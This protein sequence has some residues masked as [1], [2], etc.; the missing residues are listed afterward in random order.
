[1]R[2]RPA[3]Q[4]P[5]SSRA[6]TD[7]A[8]GRLR[9]RGFGPAAWAGFL[10]ECSW[11]SLDQVLAHPR[12]AVELVGAGA[13]LA[14]TGHRRAAL[15]TSVMGLT[16]LGLLG[17]GDRPL[18][19]ANRLTLLRANLPALLPN[20][21]AAAP[22]ALATDYLDGRV[23]RRVGVTAFGG[24]ADALA[25]L[26]FWNWFLVAHESSRSLRGLLAAVWVLPAAAITV[27]YFRLGQAVDYPRPLWFR[28]ASVAC[29][30]LIAMR[31]LNFPQAASAA[32]LG[33]GQIQPSTTS[34]A[35]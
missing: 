35:S 26:V 7:Q 32:R 18:G 1:M 13:G 30:L 29:Q 19:W 3:I 14:A 10:A 28:R 8:L 24:F 16:H 33:H 27:G 12:A 9:A 17:E 5:E 31:A 11:R 6:F 21:P 2:S 15:L 34:G 20:S 4:R 22:I 23:A 25:D